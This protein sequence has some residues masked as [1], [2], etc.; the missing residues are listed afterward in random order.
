[1]RAVTI[2]IIQRQTARALFQRGLQLLGE[3]RFAAATAT[4]NRHQQ[5]MPRPPHGIW[6]PLP[7][8]PVSAPLPPSACTDP[9]RDGQRISR[10][11]SRIEPRTRNPKFFSLS[12]SDGERV[13]VRGS[14]G[15]VKAHLLQHTNPARQAE[16]PKLPLPA[17]RENRRRAT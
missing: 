10:T 9:I 5:R 4:D 1:M 15:E 7:L 17:K 3:A 8:R 11:A 2:K 6:P 13:G 16:E 14:C 12:P